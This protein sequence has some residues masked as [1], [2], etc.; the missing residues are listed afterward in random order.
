MKQLSLLFVLL[1]CASR[2]AGCDLCG[3]YTP[4]LQT[5]PPSKGVGAGSSWLDGFYGAV[6]EQFTHFG[7]LQVDGHEVANPTDE[8]LDSSITQLVGGYNFSGRFALQVNV[9]LIF[10]ELSLENEG[11]KISLRR[12]NREP[13]RKGVCLVVRVPSSLSLRAGLPPS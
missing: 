7:T 13:Q 12:R 5:L 10:G 9:P 11:R 4:Q 6:A 1:A 2:V 8:H 3:C